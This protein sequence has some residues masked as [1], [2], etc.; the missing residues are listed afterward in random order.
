VSSSRLALALS[1]ACGVSCGD[2]SGQFA[3]TSPDLSIFETQVMPILARDCSFHACHGARQRFFQVLGPGRPRL[4]PL[5]PDADPLTPDELLF[6][7]DRAR[8]MI[9]RDDPA[10]SPLFLK[11]LEAVA[12][13]AGHEGTDLFG[14][15]VYQ[16]KLDPAFLVLQ[17]W[18]MSSPPPTPLAASARPSSSVQLEPSAKQ[19]VPGGLGG[20]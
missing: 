1:I 12:G 20:P 4:S 18:V 13:G 19:P 17:N 9:D 14:R 8:S 7:Y 5:T 3:I 10:R 16:S 11:P 2:P 6:N 15:N